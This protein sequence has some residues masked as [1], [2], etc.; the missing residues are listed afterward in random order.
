[1]N[2]FALLYLPPV[3]GGE[4]PPRCVGMRNHPMNTRPNS[5]RLALAVSLLLAA[6]LSGCV[7][8]PVEHGRYGRPVYR[9]APPPQP[10][11]AAP[12]FFYPER[13]Q[14]EALQERDR[15]ECYRWA[16]RET[17]SDPGMT[18]VRR[19]AAPQQAGLAGA[20]RA[21]GADVVAGAATGALLGAAV[22]SPRQAGPN[23]VIGAIFGAALGAAAGEARNRA[24]DEAQARQALAA[25]RAQAPQDN[26]RRAMSACMLGRGYNVQ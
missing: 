21:D 1:M 6:A 25:Q 10:V 3:N 11:A 2:P 9:T 13:G 19:D 24:I 14:T 26:F 17:G 7:V 15:Y 8:A 4:A 18:A 16:V 23:A 22:S 5:Q 12:M 20:P